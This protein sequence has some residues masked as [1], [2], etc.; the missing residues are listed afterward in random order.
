MC[1]FYAAADNES[2]ESQ[3]SWKFFNDETRRR[4]SVT[5]I[6]ELIYHGSKVN[7]SKQKLNILSDCFFSEKTPCSIKLPVQHHPPEVLSAIT[8]SEEDVKAVI[9]NLK[10]NKPVGSDSIPMA[11]YKTCSLTIAPVLTKL[12][13]K[14]MA[15]GQMPDIL[16]NALIFPLYKGKGARSDPSNYRPILIISSTAKILEQLIYTRVSTF[17]ERSGGLCEEQHG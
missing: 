14:I 16:K 5:C 2:H 12:F 7:D 4:K 11:F 9:S 1:F 10:A 8:F 3:K 15:A 17:L 13:N 6:P